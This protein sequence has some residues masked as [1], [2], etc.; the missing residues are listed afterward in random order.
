MKHQFQ[1]RA[2]SLI[3]TR[4]CCAFLSSKAFT[5]PDKYLISDTI[6]V[7]KMLG[8]CSKYSAPRGPVQKCEERDQPPPATFLPCQLNHE[9]ELSLKPKAEE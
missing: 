9:D 1:R 5:H 6:W 7:S 4:V 2:L 3:K 8:L